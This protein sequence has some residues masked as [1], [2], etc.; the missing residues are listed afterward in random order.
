MSNPHFAGPAASFTFWASR[1]DSEFSEGSIDP[2]AKQTTEEPS[3]EQ[4]SECSAGQYS[5]C[6]EDLSDD[7]CSTYGQDHSDDEC[8]TYEGDHSD[9]ECSAYEE[10]LWDDECSMY[11][12]D[13]S[14]DDDRDIM[15]PRRQE[16]CRGNAHHAADLSSSDHAGARRNGATFRNG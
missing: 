15:G 14:D 9:D 16:R 4:T 6:E 2:Q 13:N 11:G 7:E 8:P 3:L 12:E 5:T 10:D 1:R